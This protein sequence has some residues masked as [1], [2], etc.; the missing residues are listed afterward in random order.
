M[1]NLGLGI[2][3]SLAG[4]NVQTIGSGLRVFENVQLELITDLIADQGIQCRGDC[5]K[6]GQSS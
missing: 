4:A 1:G 5:L 6:F 2:A 3:V